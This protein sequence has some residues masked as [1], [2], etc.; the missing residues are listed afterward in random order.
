MLDELECG[1]QEIERSRD[2]CVVSQHFSTPDL[3]AFSYCVLLALQASIARLHL[4]EPSGFVFALLSWCRGSESL[5]LM[6]R[7]RVRHVLTLLLET[8][9]L[10]R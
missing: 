7:A 5:S 3:H 4:E 8:G 10:G 1:C 9:V 6:L 2:I